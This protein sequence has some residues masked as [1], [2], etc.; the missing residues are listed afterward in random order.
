MLWF[1]FALALLLGLL[2]AM[3]LVMAV[4]WRAPGRDGAGAAL[5]FVFLVVLLGA[6]AAAL[7]LPPLGPAVM[8]AYWVGPLFAAIVFGLILV[9]AAPPRPTGARAEVVEGT[10]EGEAV[11]T[12]FG[13]F[14][15]ILLLGLLLAVILGYVLD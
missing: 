2:L 13:I 6:W 9:A 3:L 12:A 4:G 15:W 7:W 14:F 10:P 11:A 5:L 1:E 8:G